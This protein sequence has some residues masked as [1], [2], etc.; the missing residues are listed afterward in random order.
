VRAF[1]GIA[2][3]S[4]TAPAKLFPLQGTIILNDARNW[5]QIGRH[6]E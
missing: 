3:D 2:S 6:D 5:S 1:A 4:Q